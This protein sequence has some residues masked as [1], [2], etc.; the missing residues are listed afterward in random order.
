MCVSVSIMPKGLSGKRTVHEG[1]AG[2]KSTLRRFHSNRESPIKSPILSFRP[3]DVSSSD[4]GSK[5]AGL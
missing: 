3:I 1:N 2:R 4:I 5:Y